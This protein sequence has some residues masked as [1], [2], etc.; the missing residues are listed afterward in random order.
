VLEGCEDDPAIVCVVMK[1]AQAST[2]SELLSR[3][4]AI[5]SG[6]SPRKLLYIKRREMTLLRHCPGISGTSIGLSLAKNVVEMH[7]GTVHV[8]S[9]LGQGTI[10]MITL[11]IQKMDAHTTKKAA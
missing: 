4:N 1:T 11:P 6:V 2:F 9:R 5:M 8:E 3:A 7:A 10:F